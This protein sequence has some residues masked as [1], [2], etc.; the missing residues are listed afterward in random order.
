VTTQASFY[1]AKRIIQMA[2]WDAGLVPEGEEPDS[3]RYANGMTRLNDLINL[4]QTRGLKLFLLQDVAV[5]LTAGTALYTF[6]AT[7]TVVMDK[8]LQILQGYYSDASGIRRPLI[9]IA[10]EEW[11]RLSQVTQVGAVSNFFEDKQALVVNVHLW[12][13][14]DTTAATGTVHFVFRT[15]ASLMVSLTDNC[16]FPPE[17]YIALR[18]GLADELCT[19]QPQDIQQRCATRARMFLEDLESWDMEDAPTT[20]APDTRAGFYSHRT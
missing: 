5:A 4:W 16:G 15:Q 17:W 18:W 20:F 14:P 7:G 1:T 8:P 2:Y 3:L 9:P 10:W 13:V 11:T 6:G 12:P 19:G